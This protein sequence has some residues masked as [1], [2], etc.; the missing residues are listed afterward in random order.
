MAAL[1]PTLVKLLKMYNQIIE[2]NLMALAEESVA[3]NQG[4]DEG[5]VSDNG[6]EEDGDDNDDEEDDENSHNE[7]EDNEENNDDGEEVCAD[8]ENDN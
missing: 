8:E 4:G 3:L 6:D 1:V 7:G 5:S 2:P